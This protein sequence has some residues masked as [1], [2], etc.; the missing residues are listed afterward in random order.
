MLGGS[1]PQT[2]WALA[3]AYVYH[4]DFHNAQVALRQAIALDPGYADA[5]A[6][7]AWIGNLAGEPTQSLEYMRQASIF[8]PYLSASSLDVVGLSHYV[9]GDYV[10]ARDIFKESLE[11]NNENITA[12]IFLVPTLVRLGL[13]EEA[14]WELV[15][16]QTMNP[17]FSIE[18]WA[19]A[20]PFTDK[21]VLDT[22]LNEFSRASPQ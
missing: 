5:Y 3:F 7:L 9:L 18:R 12:R 22:L 21:E 15:E 16:L 11:R 14:E 2:Y 4:R 20:Q 8:D 17:D 13:Q 19:R 6:L 10:T 1:Q